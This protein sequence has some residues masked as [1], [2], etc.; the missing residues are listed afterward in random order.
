VKL[1][2]A[3]IELCKIAEN[4]IP[5]TALFFGDPEIAVEAKES[6]NKFPFK[7]SVF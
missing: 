6:L 5:T 3:I 1:F 4:L 2:Y 7:A